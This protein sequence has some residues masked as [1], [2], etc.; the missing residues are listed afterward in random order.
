MHVR[1]SGDSANLEAFLTK[2]PDVVNKQFGASCQTPLHGAAR[3]GREDLARLLIAHRADLRARDKYGDTPLQ[4]AAM[5]GRANVVTVLLASGAD[6]N[7]IGPREE[8]PLRKAI[9]GLPG[10]D[11]LATRLEVTTLLLAAGADINAKGPDGRTALLSAIGGAPLAYNN[12]RMIEFLLEH[13]ADVHSRDLQGGGAIGY[14]AG[15]GNGKVLKLLLNRGADKDGSGKDAAALGEALSS[16]AYGGYVDIAALLLE[17]GADVNWR[18][19]G[20]ARVDEWHALPLAAALMVARSADKPAMARRHEVALA[21]IAHGA[22]VNARK[23]SGETLLHD[24]AADGDLAAIDLLLSHGA[25]VGARDGAGFT[26]LHRAVQKGHVDAATR[27]IASGA[28][29]RAAAADGTTPLSLADGDPEMEA[30]IHR[31]AKN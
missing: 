27:L 9:A 23:E 26:P 20:P 8:P 7:A 15:A 25:T 19:R 30:L 17:R 31:Y 6:A 13:G 10:A 5:S 3:L 18:Y 16:A 11:D 29:G 1:S 28:N 22:D 21:L 2:Y 12:D 24:A 14:A 4:T